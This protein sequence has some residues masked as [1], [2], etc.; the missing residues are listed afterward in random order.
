MGT[1][2][3][4]GWPQK[5]VG[6]HL[7]FMAL[8]PPWGQG[9]KSHAVV[10]SRGTSNTPS[11][12]ILQ[13]PEYCLRLQL[14]SNLFVL[15]TRFYDPPW[16]YS[17]APTPVSFKSAHAKTVPNQQQ[18]REWRCIVCE[19]WDTRL[20]TV[21]VWVSACGRYTYR[22]YPHPPQRRSFHQ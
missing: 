7:Q 21:T 4:L 11:Y 1:G 5:T 3:F 14:N 12:L 19:T 20:I 18:C 2:K 17:A 10:P 22:K 15:C 13:K 6:C 8:F 9:I 16:L